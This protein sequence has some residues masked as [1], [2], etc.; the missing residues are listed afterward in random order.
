MGWYCYQL[1]HK[2]TQLKKGV[3]SITLKLRTRTLAQP[4]TS[5]QNPNK[6]YTITNNKLH[7]NNT[8]TFCVFPSFSDGTLGSVF[9]CRISLN[10]Q[11]VRHTGTV[12]DWCMCCFCV[13][14]YWL[15]CSPR[16]L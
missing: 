12:K 11:S 16:D 1:V 2:T 9:S 3:V 10:V 13:V 8:C 4:I 14:C 5:T 15:L 7:K 6:G